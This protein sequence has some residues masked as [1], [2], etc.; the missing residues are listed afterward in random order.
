VIDNPLQLLR[1]DVAPGT[2]LT[3]GALLVAGRR[4]V[5]RRRAAAVTGIAALILVATVGVA[6]FAADRVPQPPA[7]HDPVPAPTGPASSD[8]AGA[9][10]DCQI[11]TLVVPD[12][13]KVGPVVVDATG[14][15]AAGLRIDHKGVVI[16]HDG[17]VSSQPGAA[18]VTM[19]VG[20]SSTG[21]VLGSGRRNA[22]GPSRALILKDGATS[23]LSLPAGW[24]DSTLVYGTGINA[25][26]DMVGRAGGGWGKPVRWRHQDPA[27]PAV[28]P[29]PDDRGGVPLAIAEDGLVGGYVGD[30][31][32]PRPYLWRTDGTGVE[33]PLPAGTSG[34]AVEGLSSAFAVD[35]SN[36]VRWL[37]VSSGTPAPAAIPG[38][39]AVGRIAGQSVSR[40]GTILY[41]DGERSLLLHE[42]RVSDLPVPAGAAAVRATS[43]S[44]TGEVVGGVAT[45]LAQTVT[46][47]PLLWR[48]SAA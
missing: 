4:R 23:E 24:P 8:P 12:H 31:T 25:A 44:G 41:S 40:D 10:A 29:T 11:T 21:T 5:R 16:W 38:F 45:D 6:A 37:L 35:A 3:P 27:H 46:G 14:R 19:I 22:A 32:A 47:N 39:G 43:L 15:W 7:H 13:S 42:G 17:K 33:L 2:G 18:E 9:R 34:G 48:C 1:D 36:G 30:M 26:G 28:L 20:V